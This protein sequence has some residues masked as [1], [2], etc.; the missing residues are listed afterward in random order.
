[1]IT[2]KKGQE[3]R[4]LTIFKAKGGEKFDNLDA[5]TKEDIREA[6]LKE[7][8][9]LC[10]YCM[11]R[12]GRDKNEDGYYKDVK[13]EHIKPRS[14]TQQ[15][16]DRKERLLELDFNNLVA[17]CNGI[18]NGVTHCD[19]SKENQTIAI[20]PCNSNVEDS[21]SYGLKDGEIKSNNEQWNDDLNNEKKL[22]LNFSTIKLNRI[23]ALEG[24]KESLKKDQNWSS[25]HLSRKLN[26]LEQSPKK[27]P[28]IGIIKYY[29]RKKISSL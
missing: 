17:V 19:T 10:A 14:I 20:H 9:F 4:S 8:G 2:I 6:L 12:I 13:I 3:P 28:Y 29:L 7:Q 18:T 11:R 27:M 22:N 15:S 23:S 16:A 26:D 21:I 1:M 25:S 24:I 5:K